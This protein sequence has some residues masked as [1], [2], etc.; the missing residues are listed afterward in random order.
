MSQIASWFGD[1]VTF[2]ERFLGNLPGYIWVNNRSINT[3]IYI[4]LPKC[5][6]VT[7]L[8]I[9]QDRLYFLSIILTSAKVTK[10]DIPLF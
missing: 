4:L 9:L 2:F 7:Q 1:I 8:T 10:V 6:S 3:W 5:W